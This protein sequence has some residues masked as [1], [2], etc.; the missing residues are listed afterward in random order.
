VASDDD[1]LNLIS[2]MESRAKTLRKQAGLYRGD[3]TE[4]R[5]QMRRADADADECERLATEY[6]M[7]LSTRALPPVTA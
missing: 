1:A 4:A 6:E 2:E 3:A 5:S 7:A